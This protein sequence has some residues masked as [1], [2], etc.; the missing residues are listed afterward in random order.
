MTDVPSPPA[1]LPLGPGWHV[2]PS[3]LTRFALDPGAADD[4]TGASIETHLMSCPSCR[5]SLTTA[6]APAA[7][8]LSWDAVADRIDRPRPSPVER[9]LERLG[10]RG[11]LA[12][13]V[14][15]TPALQLAGLVAIAG[16]AVAAS[17]LS[18]SADAGGPFLVLAPLVPL[19][20]VA[21][22]FTPAADP[23]GE[24][25]VAT[26]L[27]G[28]GLA[29][30]RAAFVAGTTVVLLGLAA[31]AVPGVGLESAAWVLPALALAVGSLALGTWWRVEHCAGG[32]AIAW[33]T[34]IGSVRLVEGRSIV[35]RETV[36]FSPS[37]QFAAL[38][39]VLVAAAIL[40]ARSD[41]Y[42]TLEARS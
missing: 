29:L 38:A 27:H 17:V 34:V 33:A 7:V 39:L 36:L 22:V 16:L 24:T 13:L 2:P 11:D 15:A 21:A 5:G 3:V 41:R 28:A 10:L 32:L 18:R 20:A 31:L 19:A 6:A 9:L 42:A 37:G 40:T 30:R 26:P 4:V 23:A 35:L 25:G 12:R 8:A 1:E 14:V